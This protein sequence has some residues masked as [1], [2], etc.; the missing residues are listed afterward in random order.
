MVDRINKFNQN[1]VPLRLKIVRIYFIPS[2]PFKLTIIFAVQQKDFILMY[3][4][5]YVHLLLYILLMWQQKVIKCCVSKLEKAINQQQQWQKNF[6][7]GYIYY[8]D[9]KTI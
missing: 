3:H 6:I 7:I 8:S 9:F 2:E 1:F 5:W 4:V